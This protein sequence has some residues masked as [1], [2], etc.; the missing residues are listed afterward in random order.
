MYVYCVCGVLSSSTVYEGP[1]AR[2]E[3]SYQLCVCVCVID[4]H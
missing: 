3:E 2:P 1:I 4:C